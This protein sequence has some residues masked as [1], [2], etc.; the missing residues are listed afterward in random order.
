MIQV[1]FIGTGSAFTTR[2]RTNIAL[3]V[4]HGGSSLLIECG[5][6]ILFQL[7][8][9]NSAPNQI[10]YLF[11][12]HRHGDHILGLPMFL[13]MCSLG[14]ASKSV[15][16]LGNQDVIRAG[17]ELT[18]VAYPELDQRL[19][20]VTWTDM[21]IDAPHRMQLK[22]SL[23]LSTLPTRHSQNA[24]VLALR[25]D[26]QESGHSLVYTGDTVYNEEIAEFA[27]GCDLLIHEANFSETLHPGVKAEG[28]GHSTVRQAARTAAQAQCDIL[29]LVHLASDCMGCEEQIHAEA[30]QAFDGQIMIPY[31]GATLYLPEL[32]STKD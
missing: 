24:P 15:T 13:L 2:R 17:Q 18:H 6:A 28:Y 7:D 23:K 12:S 8:Q 27:V 26:F 5:P 9:A 14:G 11:I 25:L 10:D 32:E 19:D 16:I 1:T 29:A 31:D 30:A 22:P 4:R 21:P 3:L 20:D